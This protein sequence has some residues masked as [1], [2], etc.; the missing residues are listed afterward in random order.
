M[1]TTIMHVVEQGAALSTTSARELVFSPLQRQWHKH[2]SLHTVGAHVSED[3][4]HK[5]QLQSRRH[6]PAAKAQQQ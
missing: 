2:I 3:L 4:V 6:P 1:S 5:P